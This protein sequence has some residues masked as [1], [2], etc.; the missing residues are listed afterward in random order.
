MITFAVIG[1]YVLIILIGFLIV[2][3][4]KAH[5]MGDDYAIEGMACVFWPFT[6]TIASIYFGVMRPLTWCFDRAVQA[7][8]PKLSEPS[9]NDL[10]EVDGAKSSYRNVKYNA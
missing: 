2:A 10:P 9:R 1:G 5:Y 6:L 4:R 3:W 8:T 7:F